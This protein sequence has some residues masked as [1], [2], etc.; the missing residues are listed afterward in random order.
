MPGQAEET[1]QISDK[2]YGTF[3]IHEPVLAELIGCHTV[4]RLKGI[5]QYGLPPEY[6]NNGNFTRYDH[7]IG[8]L[9]LL[10]KLG[11]DL[12]EQVAGLLHDVS[13]TA[14]SHLTNAILGTSLYT[15]LQ[16]QRHETFILSSEVAAILKKHGYNPRHIA[17]L[18]RHTLLERD[19]PELCADRIDYTLRELLHHNRPMD[20]KECVDNLTTHK[21]QI[22]FT[23]MEMAVKFAADYLYVMSEGWA[24]VEKTV[25]QHFFIH[26]VQTALD[27]DIISID[28]L[29]ED[30][31][32]VLGKITKTKHP[33]IR[34]SL[35]LLASGFTL[36]E[37]E[38]RPQLSLPR[39]FQYV[40]PRFRYGRKICR[41]SEISEGFAKLVESQR[42]IHKKGVHVRFL[43]STNLLK[44]I[45]C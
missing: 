10:R 32:H 36:E 14:F 44:K 4:Q 12:T 41:L 35:K 45:R 40:D 8:V 20:L 30:D 1:M 21:D 5:Q 43:N 7:S 6:S 25:R 18:E 16:D 33:T 9:L 31:A 28:D 24:S 42:A 26:A 19:L 13:H 29:F 3:K 34:A 17:D 37:D 15:D 11:A 22:I 2:L 39:D 27:E 23:E 38:K